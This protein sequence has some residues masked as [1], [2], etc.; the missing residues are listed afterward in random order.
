MAE[1]QE[2]MT[3]PLTKFEFDLTNGLSAIGQK[4]SEVWQMMDQATPMYR[5][6]SVGRRQYIS[7][8]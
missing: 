2:S 8:T 1:I 6:N 3:S 7:M 4:N 5:C